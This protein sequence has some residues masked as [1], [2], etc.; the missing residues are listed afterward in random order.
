MRIF[1]TG[2]AGFLGSHIAA[3]AKT[4]GWQVS[5]I[6]SF[7][8]GD[9]C[10]VPAGVTCAAINCVDINDQ[11]GILDGVDVVYHCAAAPYEGLSVFSPQ[12]VYENTL[13]STVAAL[14]AAV[15]ANVRRFIFCS[16]M[17]RYGDQQAPFTEDMPVKPVDPYA[18]AKVA[19][20]SI[21]K[22]LCELHGM[23]WVIAVP[24][25]IYG[26]GQRYYDPFRNVAGIMI[27][28]ILLGKPPIIYG[29]GQQ[30]R[31][32]S[33]IADVSGP[34]ME[35]ATADVA[36]E[37]FNLGPDREDDEVTIES[38]AH[39]I[40]FLLGHHG[41]DLWPEFYPARPAEV[42]E[43]HCSSWKARH[44]LGYKPHWELDQGLD[45]YIKWVKKKGAREFEYHLPVE[46]VR[47]NT[48]R[49]WTEKLI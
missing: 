38:L 10:N 22:N 28:R 15:N 27:N 5:G 33:Y 25:N 26:P 37:V 29:T 1:V 40:R 6:D 42:F 45:E 41:S 17:S 8:G 21:V 12:M 48:P 35:L 44:M 32:L 47:D 24:H 18:N 31:S 2:I 30:V 34:L 36:G 19:A 4:R 16:S 20:E 39:V 9:V 43:A 3:E 14:R 46:I 13:M 7:L 49:T 23:E 11:P